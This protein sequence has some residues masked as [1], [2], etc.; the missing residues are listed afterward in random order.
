MISGMEVIGLA[1]RN[2]LD[3]R[4]VRRHSSVKPI[5]NVWFRE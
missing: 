4:L 2:V 1:Q 3:C 5:W